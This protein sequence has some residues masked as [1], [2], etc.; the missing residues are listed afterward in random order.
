MDLG[1]YANLIILA[2]SITIVAIVGLSIQSYI[3]FKLIKNKLDTIIGSKSGN[4]NEKK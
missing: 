1:Q 4:L 2:Y 3:H